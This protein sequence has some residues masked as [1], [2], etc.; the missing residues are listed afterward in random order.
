MTRIGVHIDTSEVHELADDIR[1]NTDAFPV[2]AQLATEKAGFDIEAI[3]KT[4]SP[5]DTG[6]NAGSISS[7]V[8]DL[9][10]DVGPTSDYGGI[11]ELGVPHPFV[12]NAKPGG[13]LHFVIDGQDV[14]ARSVTHPPIAPRPYMGPAFDRVLPTYEDALGD[15]G[16][17]V[18]S[19]V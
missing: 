4:L 1:R 3:S 10:V 7:D 9:S 16:E 5:Y 8:G 17:Q 6:F 19:R 18:I 13:M 11:L 15:L 14:F 12:I 2:R